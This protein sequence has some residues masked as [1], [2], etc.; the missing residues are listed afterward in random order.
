MHPNLK[1]ETSNIHKILTNIGKY[2]LKG[3]KPRSN[4]LLFLV[5]S[6]TIK[7]F[8]LHKT[9]IAINDSWVSPF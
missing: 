8:I 2:S 3:E 1:P 6:H 4:Y 9:N 5:I 7:F